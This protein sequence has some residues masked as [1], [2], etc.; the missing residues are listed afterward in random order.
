MDQEKKSL[1]TTRIWIPHEIAKDCRI[2]GDLEQVAPDSPTQG[3][4]LALILHGSMGH[5]DYLFQKK[6]AKVLTMDSY[7]FDFRGNHETGGV[8]KM[9]ALHEDVEDIQSVARYMSKVFGYVVDV[10]VGHSRG[11]VSAMCWVTTSPDAAGVRGFVNVSGRYRMEGIH[12][13]DSL[14]K[15][16][17]DSKGYYEWKAIVARKEVIGII[18]PE[19]VD[20]FASWDSS[21]L[22][23]EFPRSVHVL[24]IHGMK[25]ETVP[26]YD[27]IIYA[28][29]FGARTPGT[30]NLHVL[31]NADHNF[32]ARSAEVVEAVVKWVSCLE[33]EKLQTGVWNPD[34]DKIENSKL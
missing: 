33:Q 25:D 28:R 34:A 5:K 24:T 14:Y 7:R 2:A 11:S 17:F 26:L 3:R 9:A 21:Y 22:W 30:H 4:K 8:W 32:T 23:K 12:Y 13:R 31:E 16:S 18:R 6:L 27:A 20:E 1:K 15:S 19:D 10:I 29:L